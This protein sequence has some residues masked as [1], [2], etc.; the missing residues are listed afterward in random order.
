M[1]CLKYYDGMANSID[2]DTYSYIV[3][4]IIIFPT[5]IVLVKFKARQ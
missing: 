3:L 5:S 4:Q 1:K 2:P